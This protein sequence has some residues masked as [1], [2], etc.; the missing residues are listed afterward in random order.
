MA[1]TSAAM[2]AHGRIP[3]NNSERDKRPIVVR[4]F[5]EVTPVGRLDRAG[6]DEGAAQATRH[7]TTRSPIAVTRICTPMH[8]SRNAV[9]RTM[10]W[11]AVGPIS[12]VRRSA[13]R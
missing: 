3:E 11:R 4:Q 10:T 1:A 13:K 6:C 5:S 2:T 9:S 12:P 7:L 8:M